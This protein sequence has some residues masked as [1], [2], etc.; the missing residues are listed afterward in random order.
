MRLRPAGAS[1]LVIEC[2]DG[3]QVEAWR[4]ELW[5]RREAGDLQVTEIVPGECTV[6]LDGVTPESAARLATWPEPD[7]AEVTRGPLVEIPTTFDGED[8][9]DVASRWGTTIA[10][11]IDRLA[12][13]PLTVA[14]CGFAP[15]FAYLR[16]LPQEWAVPRLAAPRPRVPAGS[17]AL[18]GAYAGIY[19]S[20]SPGGWRLV[21]HTDKTL[22]QVR[23][24]PPALLSPGTR[25]HLVPA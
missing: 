10:E 9:P 6:L 4:A 21:G 17:V 13:T 5:R 12:G 24:E 11:A 16:G 19:P 25:V 3:E 18:A 23:G 15:G 14:F 7:A 1:A 22:W 2:R 8:L 20:A